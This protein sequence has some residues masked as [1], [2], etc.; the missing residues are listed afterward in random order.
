[1]Q[2]EN[3][4]SKKPGLDKEQGRW[5]TVSDRFR[6]LLK[7]ASK[8]ENLPFIVLFLLAGISLISRLW[9]IRH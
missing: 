4:P 7:E 3:A 2:Q 6:S 5:A 8:L 1:M 9:L